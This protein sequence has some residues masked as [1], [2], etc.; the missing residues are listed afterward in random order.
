MLGSIRDFKVKT[1]W[2]KQ[3]DGREDQLDQFDGQRKRRHKCH[4]PAGPADPQPMRGQGLLIWTWYY[5]FT[6]GWRS[7]RN[8]VLLLPAFYSAQAVPHS[9]SQ[10]PAHFC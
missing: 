10:H 3:K 7:S 1:P 4:A 6:A 9:L 2:K 8:F 5:C